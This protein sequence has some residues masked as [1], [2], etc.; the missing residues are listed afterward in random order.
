MEHYKFNF[1]YDCVEETEEQNN[2]GTE[3]LYEIT[4]QIFVDIKK[5]SKY[6]KFEWKEDNIFISAEIVYNDSGNEL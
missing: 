6:K 1:D 2:V 5:L 3:C 4:K